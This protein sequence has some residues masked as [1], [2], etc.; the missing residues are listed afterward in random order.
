MSNAVVASDTSLASRSCF[1]VSSS[2][3][4]MDLSSLIENPSFCWRRVGSSAPRPTM[5]MCGL[6][7]SRY[8]ILYSL[9]S[10]MDGMLLDFP[11]LTLPKNGCWN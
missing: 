1:A 7:D 9:S 8:H 10:G 3:D 11:T 2:I 5:L 6:L 4:G